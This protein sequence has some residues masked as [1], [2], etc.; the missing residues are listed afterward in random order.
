[1]AGY[2]GM[3]PGFVGQL[4]AMVMAARA[5]G[6]DVGIGS[7]YRSEERQAQLWEQ[8]LAKYGDPEI[9]DNWVARPGRSNHGKGTAADLTFGNAA[10]RE[11]VHAN[12]SRFGMHFPMDWEPWH[13][14]PLGSVQASDRGAYTTPPPGQ[15]HPA[16]TTPDPHDLG[17]QMGNML[18]MLSGAGP[19]GAEMLETPTPT[20]GATI[21]DAAVDTPM[22]PEE[23]NG[24]LS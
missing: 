3:N 1:M 5:A 6:F 22:M 19:M 11:W 20:E 4:Q 14:E 7:G 16:D 18:S 24:A 23:P 12:A 8:A 9:A 21:E 15:A 13:I 2:E 17:T 10:A